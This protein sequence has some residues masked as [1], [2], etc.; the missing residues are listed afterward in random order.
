MKQRMTTNGLTFL[1]LIA[2]LLAALPVRGDDL[3]ASFQNPPEATKPR[4]YW[5][6]MDGQVT[7]A[8]QH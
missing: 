4:C 5:Y 3:E 6:W 7:R 8:I 2:L 1:A